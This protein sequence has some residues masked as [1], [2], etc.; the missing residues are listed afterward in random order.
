MTTQLLRPKDAALKAG[1]SVSHLYALV[2]K[3]EFPQPVKISERV[4]AFVEAEVDDWIQVKIDS[5]RLGAMQ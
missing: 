2:A 5:S 4:T 1:I 3:N